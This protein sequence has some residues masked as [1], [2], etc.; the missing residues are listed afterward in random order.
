[1]LVI[2]RLKSLSVRLVIAAL[3]VNT[4]SCGTIL[5]PER[6][7]QIDGELDAG[8]VVLDAIG[9]LFFLIPGVI[10]FAVDFSNGT[11]Y[12]PSGSADIQHND[13][14]TPH[15]AQGN[16]VQIEGELTDERIAEAVSIK[17]GVDITMQQVQQARRTQL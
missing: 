16:W 7:G 12:L 17:S 15:S 14:T 9:L 4:A 3:L 2:K 11:I 10:A 5:Y 1:M 13:G 8:V 6:K